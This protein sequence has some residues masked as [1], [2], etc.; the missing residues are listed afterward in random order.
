M[1]MKQTIW[2]KIGWLAWVMAAL[3]QVSCVN[4]DDPNCPASG[5]EEHYVLNLRVV[6]RQASTRAAGHDTENAILAENYIDL[7]GGDYR[8]LVFDGFGRLIQY[9]EPSQVLQH[10]SADESYQ[11]Y[12]FAGPLAAVSQKIQVAVAANWLSMADEG[13]YGQFVLDRTFLNGLYDTPS[14]GIWNFT[15]PTAAPWQPSAASSHHGIPMF[16][17]SRVVALTE[18]VK[19]ETDNQVR[20]DIRLGDINMLRAV[21]KIEVVDALPEGYSLAGDMTLSAYHTTGRLVPDIAANPYWNTEGA[22]VTSP[23]L[24]AGVQSGSGLAFF[25]EQKSI[26][27]VERTVYSA[28][29]TEMALTNEARPA[30]RLTVKSKEA[31]GESL[32]YDMP[33]DNYWN[34][35]PAQTLSALLRNHI[36]RYSIN[37]ANITANLHL[38]VLPWDDAD[39]ET[40]EYTDNVAIAEEGYLAW[41]GAQSFDKNTARLVV[42]PDGTPA[43]GN[44]TISTPKN[45]S[46]HAYLLT[47]S[48]DPD[49]FMFVDADGN[50]VAEPSGT[51]DGVTPATIR[52]KPRKTVVEQNNV[53]RLQIMVETAGRWLVADVCEGKPEY[54]TIIQNQ[55]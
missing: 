14:D 53:A 5:K 37:S 46:W 32:A 33:V 2:H 4:D 29:V 44:F 27:G 10:P 20:Y 36:Y 35:Q 50:E 21:A 54:C 40:W 1:R 38:E 16:G 52:V 26:G 24:P 43:I 30:I 31:G 41:T 42:N 55:N 11:I 3:F 19:S 47:E 8:I 7:E 22:Q 12:S 49:A 15:L 28:Y 17:C 39:T 48:G 51:I 45:A 9:F 13:V 18:A 23:T 25:S 6:T 34:G